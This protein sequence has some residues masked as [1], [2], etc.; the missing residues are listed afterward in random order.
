MRCLTLERIKKLL[1]VQVN[2]QLANSKDQER[3][4]EVVH[5]DPRGGEAT[6]VKLEVLPSIGGDLLQVET[7]QTKSPKR[8]DHLLP[9][10]KTRQTKN[11]TWKSQNQR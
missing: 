3:N 8:V 11:P 10:T 7:C 1:I 4:K 5:M 9:S 6:L 2:K